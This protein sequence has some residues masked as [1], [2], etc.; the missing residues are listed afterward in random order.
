MP[1]LGQ[2]QKNVR[3]LKRLASRFNRGILELIQEYRRLEQRADHVQ[4]KLRE[5]DSSRCYQAK[6][7]RDG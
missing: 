3:A 7:F 6:N 2:P 4:N 5:C 1:A